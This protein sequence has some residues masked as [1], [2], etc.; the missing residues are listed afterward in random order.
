MTWSTHSRRIDPITL[1]AKEFCH[2]EPGAMGLSRMPVGSRSAFRPTLRPTLVAKHSKIKNPHNVFGNGDRQDGKRDGK[3][4]LFEDDHD[5][6][7]F[8]APEPFLDHRPAG[9]EQIEGLRLLDWLSRKQ[10][11]P[12]VR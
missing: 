4:R 12:V 3:N 8:K 1:S 6:L 5:S 11:V 7:L 9:S 10:V 2:G